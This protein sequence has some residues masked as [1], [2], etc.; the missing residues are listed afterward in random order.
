MLTGKV[1]QN[2]VVALIFRY[3]ADGASGLV[4]S[5]VNMD[6]TAILVALFGIIIAYQIDKSRLASREAVNLVR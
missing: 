6:L 2:V 5:G 3:A 4:S 1:F